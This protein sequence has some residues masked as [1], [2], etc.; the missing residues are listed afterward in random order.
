MMG[1]VR[2]KPDVHHTEEYNMN[3]VFSYTEVD[4]CERKHERLICSRIAYMRAVQ[5]E[6]PSH[7]E[8]TSRLD[9]DCE[10]L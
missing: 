2:Y 7:S 9:Q 8:L 5:S 10:T 4:E 1:L 3:D 6:P